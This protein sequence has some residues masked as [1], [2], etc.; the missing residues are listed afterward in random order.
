MVEDDQ[1]VGKLI[2]ERMTEVPDRLYGQDLSSNY[3]AQGRRHTKHFRQ[4]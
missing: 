3:Q 1:M 2:Y 4:N